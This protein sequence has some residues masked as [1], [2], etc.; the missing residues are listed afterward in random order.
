MGEGIARLSSAVRGAIAALKRRSLAVWARDR[1]ELGLWAALWTRFA[2]ITIWSVRGVFVHKLSLQAAALAYYTLFSIVPVLVVA[3]WALKL[4]HLIPYLKA[5]LP[6]ASV[7]GG[8]QAGTYFSDTNV[9]LREAVRGIL[10][11]VDRADKV[12]AGIVG[13]A[14]LLYGA[15]KQVMHVEQAIDSVAGARARPPKY[16]RMLGYLVLLALPPALLIVSGLLRGLARLPLGSTFARAMAWLL[17][18]VP[19]LKSTLG[20]VVG[21][22]ILSTALA[23]FYGSAARARIARVSA[24]F[25]GAV[26]AVSLA[27]VLWA[28]RPPADRR[29]ACGHP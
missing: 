5:D 8:A 28:L 29:V 25:G 1:A 16:R 24:L 19:L 12:Q 27:A 14:A 21:L 10:A 23:I 3:L 2:R 13:L 18:T 9:F 4:F 7:A 22:A 6:A 17:A 26:G 20:V 11:A 15:I